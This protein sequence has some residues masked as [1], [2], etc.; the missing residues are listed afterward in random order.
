MPGNRGRTTYG[1]P[2]VTR[3]G[4]AW[5]R[6]LSLLSAVALAVAGALTAG[7]LA[8]RSVPAVS[9]PGREQPVSALWLIF[10]GGVC[11][12][13]VRLGVSAAGRR[14]GEE[15]ALVDHEKAALYQAIRWC[16]TEI[17]GL[18]RRIDGLE[19]EE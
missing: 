11:A 7:V 18:K 19:A 2:S 13:A 15:A 16:E 6:K 8:L 1:R 5:A 17:A 12:V 10:A 3:T 14:R 4:R 9:L